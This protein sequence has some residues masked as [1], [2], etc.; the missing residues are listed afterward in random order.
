M[1]FS[2]S[3]GAAAMGVA[4]DNHVICQWFG[5]AEARRVCIEGTPIGR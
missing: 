5:Y 3:K 1:Y 4:Q 2:V